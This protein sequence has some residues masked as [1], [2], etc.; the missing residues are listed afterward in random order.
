MTYHDY[1]C[2]CNECDS[3]KWIYVGDVVKFK[4]GDTLNTQMKQS[5]PTW[6]GLVT[7]IGYESCKVKW[8]DATYWM[9]ANKWVHTSRLEKM[10][11][12]R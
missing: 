6:Y 3:S 9:N 4:V 1:N 2:E 10:S 12:K 7:G 8:F 11:A 5:P